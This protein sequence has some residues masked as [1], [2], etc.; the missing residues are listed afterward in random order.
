MLAL[1]FAILFGLSLLP[2]RKPLCLRFAERISGGIMPEGAEGYCRGL[3]WIWFFLLLAVTVISQGLIFIFG[4]RTGSIAGAVISTS[5]IALTFLVEGRIRRKRFSVEFRT[6]GSTGVAKSIVKT[7][8][9][10]AKEVD[11]HRSFYR[12]SLT[13]DIT[14]LSTVSPDHMYGTLWRKM[15]PK[16]ANLVCDESI[17]L[18]PEELV[19]KMKSAKKVFLVTTPSFLERFTLYSSQYEVPRNCMEITTSGGPLPPEVSRRA[20]EVFGIVPREIYGSTETGGI[21]SRRGDSPWELF[22]PVKARSVEGRLEVRS[23]FSFRKRHLMGDA[24]D[25]IDDRH[26]V[27]KGRV[28]R[29][30]KINEE[31][32]DLAECETELEKLGFAGAALAVLDGA[33]GPVLGALL[34]PPAGTV[35]EE[36]DEALKSNRSKKSLLLRKFTQSIFPKGTVP[37]RFRFVRA[38]PRNAQ[39]KVISGEVREWLE[40]DLE[41]P[42]FR[43]QTLED[44]VFE[45]DVVFPADA[46][47]FRGHFDSFHLL[48]GVAQLGFAVRYSAFVRGISEPVKTVKRL[49]YTSIIRPGDLVHIRVER[50][51]ERETVF[52][53]TKGEAQCSS[54]T[55]V[56]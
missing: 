38:L 23:P 51:G 37:R 55:L 11:Y 9:S 42:D 19:A 27:L 6:S 18:S 35:P 13:R 56:F 15:L 31:R 30:V 33:H 21:A 25:I 49:K 48:P 45:A 24:V 52:A 29:I 47:Y 44:G 17:I 7:F 3:T 1:I 26:F 46:P 14:F 5:A 34:V 50:K 8:E 43:G 10:L 36:I 28:D 12:S 20:A 4:I 40:T 53:F 54:G 16:A 39:G 22:A 41:E 2:G 32:V